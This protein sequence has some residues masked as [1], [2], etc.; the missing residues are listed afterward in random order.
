MVDSL[1]SGH[2]DGFCV[3]A[4]WNSVAVDLGVGNILHFG[5]EM[6]ARVSEKVLAVREHWAE[7]NPG[8]LAALVRALIRASEFTDKA[9]NRTS[10]AHIVAQR[11]GTTPELVVRTL[12][13]ALK[14]KP[15]GAIRKSDRYIVI[16]RDG[17][18]R[19]D[20]V[21]A[22]W[23]YAQIV[24]WGQAPLSEELRATAERVFRP[25]LYDAAAGRAHA[26]ARREARDGI[27]AFVGPD[28]DAADI[29]GYLSAWRSKRSQRPRLSV[30]R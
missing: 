16:G 6:M 11:L 22:A 25:D 3:G 15:E 7:E 29:A 1:A 4:P 28:F 14:T 24:R 19:P 23:A 27:G 9:D 21:Q 10:V 8:A 13:G 17:A 20:P 2:V 12:T 30:V 18:N 5:C 26:P